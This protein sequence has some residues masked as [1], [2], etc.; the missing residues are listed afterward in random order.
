MSFSNP[1]LL[2]F[3]AQI[4]LIFIAVCTSLVNLSLGYGNQ[5][6]WIMVLSSS[7]GYILPNPKLKAKIEKSN[8]IKEIENTQKI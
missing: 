7:L 4:F 3:C 1:A 8:N 2:L 5:D 6:L